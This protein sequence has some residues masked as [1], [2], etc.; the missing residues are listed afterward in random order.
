MGIVTVPSGRIIVRVEG[1]K[2]SMWRL[3]SW[4][5]M[6]A[7]SEDHGDTEGEALSVIW[8]AE[9]GVWKNKNL[10]RGLN[11]CTSG[12]WL[13]LALSVPRQTWNGP[14]VSLWLPTVDSSLGSIHVLA[15]W[16]WE[17]S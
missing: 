10:H 5:S 13:L 1:R 15:P 8:K 2:C 17:H 12:Y 9:G 6:N 11:R 4:V 7:M 16:P 14:V 3:G